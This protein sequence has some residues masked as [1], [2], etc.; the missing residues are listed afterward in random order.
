MG[1]TPSFPGDSG[2]GGSTSFYFFHPYYLLYI[3]FPMFILAYRCFG[4]G[5]LGGVLTFF[6]GFVHDCFCD[7]GRDLSEE[8]VTLL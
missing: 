1:F 4:S 6:D 8:R 3:A 2:F 5:N 7:K